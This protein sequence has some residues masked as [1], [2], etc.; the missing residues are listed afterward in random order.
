MPCYRRDIRSYSQLCV[1]L[2]LFSKYSGLRVN[3]HKTEIFAVGEHRLDEASFSHKICK[4]I[5][6]L[7]IVFD[8][9][10]PSRTKG[11]FD[12]IFKSIKEMLT[13]WKWRGLTLIG[14]I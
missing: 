7:R 4:S 9:H 2:R 11:N 1:I 14:K 13:M 5:K 3:N 10:I 6:I 12:F 8:Y